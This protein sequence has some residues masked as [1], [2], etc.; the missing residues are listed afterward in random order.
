MEADAD[1]RVHPHY[2]A[3]DP[4]VAS[5]P[6][7]IDVVLPD[8]SFDLRTD[9]GVFARGRLDTGTS[10]LLRSR[11]PLAPDGDLL[12][13]GTG[14]GAIAIAMAMRA[15][16]A[17][18]WAVDV[19]ARARAL[20]AENA[21]RNKLSNVRVSPPDEVPDGVRFATIWSNP[22]IRV[23]KAALHQMLTDWLGRLEPHGTATI[24]VQRNLGADS[25]QRWLESQGFPFRRIGSKAGFRLLGF[26]PDTTAEGH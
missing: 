17:T 19:N 12:D 26:E 2:F 1:D 18:V 22:P 10:L 4:A 7:D 9:R 15:P 23:G 16:R 6:V 8:I 25:L 14:A 20:T 21:E 13:L 11:P 3:D 24:V 5:D